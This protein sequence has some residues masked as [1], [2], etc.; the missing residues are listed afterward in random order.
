LHKEKTMARV[1]IGLGLVGSLVVGL[2]PSVADAGKAGPTYLRNRGR[3]VW[4][5]QAFAGFSTEKE[6][7]KLVT[8]ARRNTVLTKD[9]K[10]NWPFHFIAFLKKAPK[11]S[12][13]NL[14]FYRLGKKREQVDFTEFA[15]P[16]KERTLQ[17][18]A[19]LKSLAGFKPNDRL[20]AR[21]TRLVNGREIVYARCR[22]RLK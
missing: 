8:K 1:S 3:I 10:G 9:A 4:Q 13:V 21:V 20:E 5:Q 22:L 17:A 11:A 19:T 7:G 6:F 15:V 16:P 2:L 12:K 14:V 18:S